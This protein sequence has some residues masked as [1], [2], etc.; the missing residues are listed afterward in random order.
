MLSEPDMVMQAFNPSTWEVDSGRD[1]CEFE[2]SLIYSKLQDSQGYVKRLCLK[3]NKQTEEVVSSCIE[4][5]QKPL[6]PP[7]P[8]V[9]VR[10]RQEGRPVQHD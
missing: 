5:L 1:L 8:G 4:Y 10:G 2:A 7:R 6:Q 9:T 3:T